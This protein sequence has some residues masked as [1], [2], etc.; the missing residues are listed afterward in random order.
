MHDRPAVEEAAKP[1]VV[2]GVIGNDIHVVANRLLQICLEQSGF[3]AFNLGTNNMPEG[4]VEAALETGAEA[5]LISSLNGEAAYWCRD[6]RRLFKDHGMDDM[7]IY[8]GG[9]IITGD[10]PADEVE[11]LFR[12]FGIDRV[13]YGSVDF[14][15]IA[16]L[17]WSDLGSGTS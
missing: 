8:V 4:F 17:L 12:G 5:T 13:F 6:L 3:R 10:H 1:V 7:T 16:Q 15:E 11:R 9:N 14:D 2:F